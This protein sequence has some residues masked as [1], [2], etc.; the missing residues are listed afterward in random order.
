MGLGLRGPLVP[1][2]LSQICCVSRPGPL[3]GP[4]VLIIII[5]ACDERYE[6]SFDVF[7]S[8]AVSKNISFNPSSLIGGLLWQAS[9]R[10]DLG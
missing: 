10:R 1:H 3:T 8:Q 6:V 4:H 5:L 7:Y 9:S 2:L